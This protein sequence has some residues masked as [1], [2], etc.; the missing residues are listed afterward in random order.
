MKKI[1]FLSLAA[2]AM[3]CACTGGNKF[4]VSGNVEG[5]ADPTN[6]YLEVANNGN[7]FILDSTTTSGGGSY[8]ISY[9]APEYPNIYRL[10]CADKS[11]YFTVN[12]IESITIDSKLKTFDKDFNIDGTEHAKQINKIE[13]EAIE[14]AKEGTPAS[15]IEAWKKQLANQILADEYGSG[16]VA[17]FIISKYINGHPLFDPMNDR[18]MKFIGAVAN[19]F[20]YTAKTIHALNTS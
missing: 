12:S 20:N 9:D 6:L 15:K 13:K 5:A 11:I 7:W 14:Y 3:L 4:K 17:Y 19:A 8:S 16:I 2:M 18:D 1:L 10:R